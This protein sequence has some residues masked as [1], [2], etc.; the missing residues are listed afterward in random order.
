MNNVN[1]L[2][3][4]KDDQATIQAAISSV[5]TFDGDKT[6]LKHG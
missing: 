4:G 5:E 3:T 2:M 6:N 1:L